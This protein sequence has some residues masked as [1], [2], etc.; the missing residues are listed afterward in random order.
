V[1]GKDED[2][3]NQEDDFNSD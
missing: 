2:L 3:I 1:S